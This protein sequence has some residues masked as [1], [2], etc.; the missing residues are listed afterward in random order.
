MAGNVGEWIS[1]SQATHAQGR[2]A[3]TRMVCGGGWS[4]PVAVYGA[5]S[6]RIPAA[7]DYKSES[8]GFRCV[9]DIRYEEREVGGPAESG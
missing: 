2:D 9:A 3:D 1:H 5:V 7:I 8:V 6:V 4:D